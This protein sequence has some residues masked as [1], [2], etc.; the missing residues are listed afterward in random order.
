MLRRGDSTCP[1]GRVEVDVGENVIDG[2]VAAGVLL[3]ALGSIMMVAGTEPV[4]DAAHWLIARAGVLLLGLAAALAMWRAV[5]R[6]ARK[7]PVALA[8]AGL[9]VL[10]VQRG[11]D[12]PVF[13]GGIVIGLGALLALLR[14]KGVFRDDVDPVHTYR[15]VIYARRIA[16]QPASRM[17]KQIKLLAVLTVVRVDLSEA[18][19]GTDPF[20]EL[21][22]T[23]WFAM[24]RIEVP[25]HWVAV[26]GRVAATKGVTF[27]GELDSPVVFTDLE[28]A[29][30]Q[31]RLNRVLRRAGTTEPGRDM[32]PADAQADVERVEQRG[33]D[34][35]A[36]KVVIHMAGAIS[37]VR[38]LGR[39]T[40]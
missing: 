13:L 15:R 2:R 32:N 25:Q 22:L 38:L 20:L 10:L 28:N 30:Q 3:V 5:P 33:E 7:A 19:P 21:V 1:A 23:G 34:V 4:L 18:Q 29:D 24:I 17:P 9:T 37:S 12:P 31:K 26:A 36:T 14:P 39:G 40:G 6:D 11:V 16:A 27:H 8:G 35:M